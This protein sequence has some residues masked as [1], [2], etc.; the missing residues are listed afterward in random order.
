MVEWAER[1]IVITSEENLPVFVWDSG[2]LEFWDIEDPKGM[3]L[4]G[5]C[6]IRNLIKEKVA[7]LLKD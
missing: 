1:I 4:A 3:D 2:K 7:E 5:H 6:R